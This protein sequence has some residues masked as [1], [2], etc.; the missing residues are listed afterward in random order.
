[1]I[2]GCRNI[3]MEKFN[4]IFARTGKKSVDNLALDTFFYILIKYSFG[5]QAY[6]N[7]YRKGLFCKSAVMV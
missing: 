6:Y 1:M 5:L 4:K 3:L 7:I 2:F